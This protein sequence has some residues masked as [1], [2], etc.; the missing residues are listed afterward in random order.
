MNITLK[1]PFLNNHF[2]FANKHSSSRKF[3]R[4]RN[5]T[6]TRGKL[7]SRSCWRRSSQIFVSH[8]NSSKIII[9]EL[10]TGASSLECTVKQSFLSTDISDTHQSE[11]LP[12][13]IHSIWGKLPRMLSK[14]VISISRHLRDPSIWDCQTSVSSEI[15]QSGA[16]QCKESQSRG[17]LSFSKESS[18]K[19]DKNVHSR[20]FPNEELSRF[21]SKAE[22]KSKS[23]VQRAYNTTNCVS[24][25]FFHLRL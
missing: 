23:A 13:K 15:C 25:S 20:S 14:A 11:A 4:S 6:L 12:F 9:S 3:Q 1:L 18:T 24:R 8:D 2:L 5:L 7:Q 22:S 17:I 10:H 16:I 21:L 19:Y